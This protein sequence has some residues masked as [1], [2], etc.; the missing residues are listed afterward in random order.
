MIIKKSFSEKT[1]EFHK[2]LI[3]K[4]FGIRDIKKIGEDNVRQLRYW[5]DND[6]IGEGKQNNK[7]KN[8][9]WDK[10]NF[11][12]FIW[13]LIVRELKELNFDN[14]IIKKCAKEIFSRPD[15]VYVGLEFEKA[16]RY[17]L[18]GRKKAFI[19]IT[20]NGT[21][22]FYNKDTF[23]EISDSDV[24]ETFVVMN[25]IKLIKSFLYLKEFLNYIID[26]KILRDNEIKVLEML[27]NS[28]TIGI[29]IETD[30]ERIVIN[31]GKNA[32]KDFI[33]KIFIYPKYNSLSINL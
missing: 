18:S 6:L 14:T 9:N 4:S 2:G 24:E 5:I 20:K 16:V 10:F 8:S 29:V 27:H 12:E 3:K 21:F 25:F 23:K 15:K 30:D 17:A 19:T 13:I 28:E 32:V 22:N 33:N 11:Y 1:I 26:C 31:P 7:T